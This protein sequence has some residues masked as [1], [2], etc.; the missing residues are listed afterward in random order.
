M[1]AELTTTELDLLC[2]WLSFVHLS[3]I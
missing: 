2:S 3:I 1:A